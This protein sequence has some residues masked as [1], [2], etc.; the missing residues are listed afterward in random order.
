MFIVRFESGMSQEEPD[1]PRS[2]YR[3]AFIRKTTGSKTAVDKAVQFVPVSS[4][5]SAEINKVF[6]EETEKIKYRPSTIVKQ[7]KAEG[8]T[9]FGMKQHTDLSRR[10]ATRKTKNQFGVEVE[11]NWFWHETWV[12]EVRKC[13]Q[14]D[15]V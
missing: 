1:D 4:E 8:F 15:E 2:W 11:G 10:A 7:M 5:A 13:C 12:G 14:E 9:R 6:L 3:V